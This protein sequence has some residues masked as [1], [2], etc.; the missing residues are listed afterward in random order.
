MRF[1]SVDDPERRCRRGAPVE[2][3][4]IWMFWTTVVADGGAWMTTSLGPL[5]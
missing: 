2:H 4:A 3:F 5:E 1:D